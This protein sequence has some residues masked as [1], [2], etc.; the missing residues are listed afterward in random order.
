MKISDLNRNELAFIEIIRSFDFLL[1]N[2]YRIKKVSLNTIEFPTVVFD[3][4]QRYN[5]I[6][7]F[8]GGLEGKFSV[9]IQ[10]TR[11]Y[12][13]FVFIS[14]KKDKTSWIFD[15]SDYYEHFDSG[16]TL[17]ENYS[18]KLQAIFIQ[19]NLMPIIE[20]EMWIDELLKKK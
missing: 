15:I 4:S 14:N 7:Y 19:K 20:G 13:S 16:M 1:R 11:W 18:L 3:A 2:H 17:G 6:V 8:H 12:D 10:R 5:R 9:T